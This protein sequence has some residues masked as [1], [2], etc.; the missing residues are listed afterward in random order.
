VLVGG[1]DFI[2]ERFHESAKATA[3][4]GI[5]LVSA[6][7]TGDVGA[8]DGQK[9]EQGDQA[10]YALTAVISVSSFGRMHDSGLIRVIPFAYG[11]VYAPNDGCDEF[12]PRACDRDCA[13]P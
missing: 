5:H 2:H 10:A 13:C 12:I 4:F 6:C 11:V 3:Q 9:D 7:G 1:F 8:H